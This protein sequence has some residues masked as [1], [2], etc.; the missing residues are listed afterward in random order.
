MSD[1]VLEARNL[2]CTFMISAGA[3]RG[4]RPLH[5][6]NG[7][8]L[9]V[10][11]GEVLALVGESGCGKTTLAKIFLGLQEPSGGTVRLNGQPLSALARLDRA[12]FV[13][14]IFQDP[15]SSLNPRKTIGEIIALPLR[16]QGAPNPASWRSQVEDIMALVGLR[17]QLH[18]SYPNQLSGGQRQRVAIARALINK[19]GLV[20]CDEPTSAL[21]VSVQ[22]QILNLL[23]D[24][25]R[26]LNLTYI[27]ISHNLAV[28]EHIATRVAV[29]YLGRIVEEADTETLFARPRHPYTAALLE[30]V[31]TPDPSL[32][33]PNTQLGATFPNPVDPPSGCAFHP[34][35]RR[36]T[37]VCAERAP[38]PVSLTD[39]TVACH[40]YD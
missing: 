19:P 35:C 37:A 22:S 24:L 28:V 5:A 4:R 11:R 9:T 31:L 15:Y 20:I 27:V 21:D 17:P 12:R 14:P 10:A 8:D 36:A 13:Q 38:R 1:T 25:R 34:R 3:F 32:G 16:V 23:Q 30:S 18:D 6:V 40:L 39:G 7:V 2:T 33:I 29:M 26:D